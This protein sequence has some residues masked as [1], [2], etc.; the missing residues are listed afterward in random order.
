ML[1]SSKDIRKLIIPLLIEQVLVMAVGM[2]DVIMLSGVGE[3]AV[4]G[5]SL[6]DTVN[7]LI[8]NIF[9]ALAT[10][11]AVVVGHYL[12]QKNR[13]DANKAAWQLILFLA[14]S[15]VVITV[16]YLAIHQFILT[17]VF[18]E[19]SPDVYK[20]ARD[21]LI[22]TAFS[23]LPISIYNG[24]AA[25]FRSM[26]KSNVT[27]W[28][29]LGMNVL[30]V[31]TNYTL[32]YIV[33]LGA[34]GAGISTTF[35]RSI[36]AIVSLLLLFKVDSVIC[37]RGRI[38][39]KMQG[40]F[41]KK[42]LYIGLPNGLENSMFQLGKIVLLS[43][44]ATL[45]THAIAANA[46]SGTIAMFNVL[47]G[48]SINYALLSVCS[49][50]VGAGQ[51]DQMRFYTKKLMTIAYLCMLTLS[52]IVIVFAHQILSFYQLTPETMEMA[53]MV[54]RYHAFMAIFFWVPSFSFSNV[55]RSTGDVIYPMV[56][57][58]ISMWIFRIGA[59]YLLCIFFDFG[60]MGVW[61]AMTVDW[62]FRGLSYFVRYRRGKWEFSM[63]KSL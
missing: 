33:G 27:M 5:V 25:L 61:I 30:H 45:G 26:G 53:A 29:S 24:A 49:F 9:G 43:L 22:Y 34:A 28:I 35:S 2:A 10:G 50:C 39:W 18:G 4:S 6:V 62:L 20:S 3:A 44:V 59:A 60:L 19:I 54:I 12:G 23:I 56:I 40:D 38:T 13:E 1:F 11:G 41:I 31:C 51:I 47:P 58:I 17:V 32:I 52:V 37:L 7:V 57:A 55:L 42:I 15:S 8:I 48:I 21:Y 36:A 16:L 14:A 63:Q 46:V